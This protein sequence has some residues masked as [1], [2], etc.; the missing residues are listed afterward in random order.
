[1]W[2]YKMRVCQKLKPTD[3]EKRQEFARKVLNL[4][5]EEEDFVDRCVI[6]DECM[7]YTNGKINTQNARHWRSKSTK[8][9]WIG[10]H[11]NQKW[12]KVNVWCATFKNCI[13]GP[14]TFTNGKNNQQHYREMLNLHA[15][16]R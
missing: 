16:P 8:P 3:L 4:L 15:F 9:V 7:C 10:Q 12:E 13:V 14:F 5:D 1:M 2:P 11:K 6:S